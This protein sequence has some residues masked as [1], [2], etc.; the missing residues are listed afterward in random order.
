MTEL[1]TRSEQVLPTPVRE[2]DAAAALLLDLPTLAQ[3]AYAVILVAFLG[4]LLAGLFGESPI[5]LEPIVLSLFLLPARAVMGLP[6]RERAGSEDKDALRALQES[7]DYQRLLTTI[8]DLASE[9]YGWERPIGLLILRE[10]IAAYSIGSWR[11]DYLALGSKTALRL[12]KELDQPELPDWVRTLLLHEIA[13]VVH[14]DQQRV[15]FS[16]Q[17]LRGAVTILPWWI[18]FIALWIGT[19]LQAIG[20]ALAFDFNNVPGIPPEV[21]GWAN[22]LVALDPTVRVEMLARAGG[23]NFASLM[24]FIVLSFLPIALTCGILYLFFWRWMVRLQEHYADLAIRQVG[25]TWKE[26]QYARGALL[27]YTTRVPDSLVQRLR[28]RVTGSRQLQSAWAAGQRSPGRRW[29]SLH[30]TFDERR[31]VLEAPTLLFSNWQR[32]A[33]S[34]A[35]LSLGLDIIL[36][37][38]LFIY[39][40]VPI[41]LY[42]L[43]VLILL[44][45]WLLPQMATGRSYWGNLGRILLLLFAVRAV[46]LVLNILLL[47]V[48]IVFLP[49]RALELLNAVVIASSRYVGELS[50]L[51][52]SSLDTGL[53]AVGG[54]ILLE[55]VQ[56]AALLVA[57]GA[58]ILWQHTLVRRGADT[59]QLRRSHWLSI[60]VI[61]LV[62]FVILVPLGRWI[63]AG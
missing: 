18:A 51:P 53:G 15:G 16:G 28:R 6:D 59:A 48:Q 40:D 58:Y 13:H 37:S 32:V 44:G 56:T 57:L 38:P 4:V 63:A 62:I 61:S 20:A 45:T 5:R 42:V 2:P 24:N 19:S 3:A 27:P 7:G 60:L 29:F 21:G 25:S 26:V 33:W 35:A 34:T 10:R 9:V 12:A 54:S 30:P 31:A 43:T 14:R 55:L 8:N 47:V 49:A 52:V 11:R 46:W 50:E 23:I 36:S 22:N 17:L 39:H 41:H 1:P